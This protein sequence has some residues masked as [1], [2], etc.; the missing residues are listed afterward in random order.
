MA[1]MISIQ[2]KWV[3]KILNGKK[4][5]EIRKT[6][7]KCELPCKVYIYCTNSGRPLV[8]GQ[9]HANASDHY[10]Q[11]YGYSRKD[12]DRIWGVLNGK[13]V[14]EFTLNKV[15]T[16]NYD[17]C[18]HPEIGYP[19]NY[20]CGDSWYEIDGF[21]LQMS[22]MAEDELKAYGEGNTVYGLYIDDLKIYDAPKEIYQFKKPCISP[23]MPYC[24]L[25]PVGGEN[26]SDEEAESYRAFGKCDTEWYC[27]NYIKKP[28]Q[29]W[30]YVEGVKC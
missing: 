21:D 14:A 4:T 27:S 3:E 13:V 12:A 22:C 19:A 23:K 9:E 1:I 5:I 24:P 28:P 26:I 29:S 6:K 2:P 18:D 10:T 25:C 17:Y 11:T 8:Y 30:C 7:P 16:Y 15:E 20:D